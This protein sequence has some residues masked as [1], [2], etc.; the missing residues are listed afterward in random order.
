MIVDV[1][2]NLNILH[3]FSKQAS[4]VV[5]SKYSTF[6]LFGLFATFIFLDYILEITKPSCEIDAII[7]VSVVFHDAIVTIRVSLRL[8]HLNQ[9]ITSVTLQMA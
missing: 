2:V 3:N 8:L 7:L 5:S 1:P 6:H 4:T 9:I